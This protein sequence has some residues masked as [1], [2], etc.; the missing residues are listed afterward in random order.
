MLEILDTHNLRGVLYRDQVE[1]GVVH[2]ATQMESVS[3]SK[4]VKKSCDCG[5]ECGRV[6]LAWIMASS[7]TLH[8]VQFSVFTSE[9]ILMM[10]TELRPR[11]E[12]CCSLC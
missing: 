9:G 4:M 12:L 3:E 8:A 2:L 11:F 7:K 6:G 5:Q 1:K 10:V